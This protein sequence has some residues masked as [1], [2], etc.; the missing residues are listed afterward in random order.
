VEPIQTSDLGKIGIVEASITLVSL[1][2]AGFVL[3]GL[4]Y[5]VYTA[6]L[7][8]CHYYGEEEEE[9]EEAHESEYDLRKPLSSDRIDEFMVLHRPDFLLIDTVAVADSESDGMS[10]RPGSALC[11]PG[12]I[13]WKDDRRSPAAVPLL[14]IDAVVCYGTINDPK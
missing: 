6:V 11:S 12:I 4:V 13:P 9:E 10:T 3:P 2:L 5:A 7:Y 14:S 1:F 8:L